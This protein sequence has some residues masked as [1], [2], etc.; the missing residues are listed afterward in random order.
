MNLSPR[1]N[2]VAELI[3]N[4]SRIADIGTDHAYLPAYLLMSGRVVSAIAADIGQGPLD[5]ARDTLLRYGLYDKIDLRLSDG[6]NAISPSEVDDICI[7]GMGGELIS[8]IIDN[9]DWLKNS[10]KRL[11]LQ[12]MSAVDDLRIYLSD[13]GFCIEEETLV[14]DAKRIYCIILAVYTGEK[15]R[16]SPEYAIIGNIQCDSDI[17]REYISFHLNR[18]NK[19]ITMLSNATNKQDITDLIEIRDLIKKRLGE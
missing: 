10:Q 9:A 2:A 17:A 15:I 12:P 18:I 6:L 5:N 7:C 11:I 3:R 16:R 19:H 8:Q 4:G 13:N 1:L 14:R